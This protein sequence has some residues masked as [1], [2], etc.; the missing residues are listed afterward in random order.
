MTAIAYLI[1]SIWFLHKLSFVR[2][3]N[4][5]FAATV[6]LFFSKLL[7]GVCYAFYFSNTNNGLLADTWNFHRLSVIETNTLLHNP[8]VFIKDFW[9]N[10][11]ETNSLFA[12][13]SSIYNNLKTTVFVKFLAILN[14]F[15]LK[16][17]YANL[18][19]LNL[20][21]FVGNLALYKL[22]VKG[23]QGNK[24]VL[25]MAVFL[26]PNFLFWQSGLHKDGLVFS[27][28]CFCMYS[29]N[30]IYQTQFKFKYVI[31]AIA[32]FSCIFF[33]KN[34]L[35]ILFL[36]AFVVYLI[37]LK[38]NSNRLLLVLTVLVGSY[39]V[40]A[41]LGGPN[42]LANKR[43]EF[44]QLPSNTLVAAPNLKSNISSVLYFFPSA[45]NMS[46]FQPKFWEAKTPFS[47]MAGLHQLAI[48]V[49]LVVLIILPKKNRKNLAIT[50][51]CLVFG[52]LLTLLNGYIIPFAGAIIRYNSF[53]LPFLV[54]GLISWVSPQFKLTG[55]F[56]R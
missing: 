40:F 39:I 24:W 37:I 1:F 4:L 41:L 3:A 2:T 11:Y 31:I 54:G 22:L 16:N 53:T 49:T 6:I 43:T 28:L 36:V 25:I 48:V 7:A 55:I 50:A 20:V 52:I 38:A 23:Y 35:S 30:A 45:L 46:L 47:F 8:I 18:I 27:F 15:T 33:I 26:L 10:K 9:E 14:V 5:G 34:Y 17:Y 21:F 44:L 29:L 12:G 42:I 51:F 56:K 19:I 13:S 32:S